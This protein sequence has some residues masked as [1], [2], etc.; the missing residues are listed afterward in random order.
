[1]DSVHVLLFLVSLTC[2]HVSLANR[3][4]ISRSFLRQRGK[5]DL[6]SYPV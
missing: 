4:Y 6:K 1:M 2:L 3:F 5:R